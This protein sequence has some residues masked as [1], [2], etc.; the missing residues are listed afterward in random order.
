MN[1]AEALYDKGNFDEAATVFTEL[2]KTS[3]DSDSRALGYL[4]RGSCYY[5][6][7]EEK[8]IDTR[9]ATTE[10]LLSSLKSYNDLKMKAISDY[11]E[12]IK[13]GSKSV[14]PAAFSGRGMAYHNIGDLKNACLDLKT[15]CEQG[16]CKWY[17]D[18]KSQCK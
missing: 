2:I 3:P 5:K 7:A 10:E 8:V 17:N 14:A 6:K 13:S 18:I 12:A 9:N 16:E 15:A 4:R 11:T 1:N